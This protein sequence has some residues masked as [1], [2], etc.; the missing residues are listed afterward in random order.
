MRKK[1]F[2][3]LFA[4][5]RKLLNIRKIK[6]QQC[7][8]LLSFSK[9]KCVLDRFQKAQSMHTYRNNSPLLV[10]ANTIN[11]VLYVLFIII[12]FIK[13]NVS[14]LETIVEDDYNFKSIT[15]ISAISP[16]ITL[17]IPYIEREF[18]TVSRRSG[19]PMIANP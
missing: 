10:K 2:R 1:T 19:L 12:N 4:F 17:T 13:V 18:T 11:N 3:P 9:R 15:N 14:F 16:R 6:D 5:E 7:V 8:H